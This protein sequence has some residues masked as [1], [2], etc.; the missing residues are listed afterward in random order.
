MKHFRPCFVLVCALTFGASAS[1]AEGFYVGAGTHLR[2]Y[3]LSQT[4]A[5]QGSSGSGSVLSGK[6]FGGYDFNDTWAIEGGYVDLGKPR[7]SYMLNGTA[8][9]LSA[10]AHAW[11]GAAKVSMPL[12]EQFGLFGKVGLDQ[13]RLEVAGTGAAAALTSNKSTTALYVGAGVQYK[14]SKNLASTLELEHFGTD[15]KPGSALNGVSLGLKF[16]F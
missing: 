1:H 4:G 7:Y 11:F 10:R 8:S 9:Q 13:H 15:K 16:N 2:H 3:D 6:L 14:I 5:S 12:S